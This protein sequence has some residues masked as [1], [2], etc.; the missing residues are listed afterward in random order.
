MAKTQSSLT[1]PMAGGVKHPVYHGPMIQPSHVGRMHEKL[2][3][4]QD[5]KI[6]VAMLQAA[7]NSSSPA[8]RK[9]ATFA[10]NA[11]SWGKK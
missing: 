5:K 3:V 11:R 8:T 1:H 7:K 4:P 9:Q 2:G 6:P 10:L